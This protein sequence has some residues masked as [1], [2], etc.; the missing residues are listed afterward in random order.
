M[1][2]KQ[3]NKILKNLEDYINENDDEVDYTTDFNE[4]FKITNKGKITK[5]ARLVHAD[6]NN[7]VVFG[8]VIVYYELGFPEKLK[9]SP[10]L[11]RQLAR[12][13]NIEANSVDELLNA[14][15]DGGL[16]KTYNSK[17]EEEVAE[18]VAEFQKEIDDKLEF[19]SKNNE[20]DEEEQKKARNWLKTLGVGALAAS[21]L[22][23]GALL[24]NYLFNGNEAKVDE[25]NKNSNTDFSK[26][27][28]EELMKVG[29]ANQKEFFSQTIDFLD[30]SYN[31][32]H[33]EKNFRICIIDEAQNI[34]T[35]LF[36]KLYLLNY[37]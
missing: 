27:S 18:C 26:M 33:K 32:T 29:N 25:D 14:L 35:L 2:I 15:V 6:E 16:L 10:E 36:K 3:Q 24:A 1:K 9:F 23:G 17:S 28:I 34:K 8:D 7:E 30:N 13:N 37:C 22:G 5:I 4:K 21:A 11:I 31:L 12:D 20:L 19:Y